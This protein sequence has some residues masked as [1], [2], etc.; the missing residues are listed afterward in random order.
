MIDLQFDSENIIMYNWWAGLVAAAFGK[1]KF[2]NKQTVLYRQH[3]K[4]QVG[5]KNIG[6]ILY[7]LTNLFDL[8]H[9]SRVMYNTYYQAEKFLNV[10]VEYLDIENR[11]IIEEYSK[12]KDYSTL[13]RLSTVFRYNFFKHSFINKIGQIFVLLFFKVERGLDL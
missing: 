3:K 1:I 5:A 11:K 8:K 4:N 6:N 12:I 7:I 9:I 13:K 10:Y 2:I